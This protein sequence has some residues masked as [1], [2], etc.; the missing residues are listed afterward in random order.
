MCVCVCVYVEICI[1][2]V[3]DCFRFGFLIFQLIE[4]DFSCFVDFKFNIMF[5]L[6]MY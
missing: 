5:L 6:I 1:S 4:M 3:T 2:G